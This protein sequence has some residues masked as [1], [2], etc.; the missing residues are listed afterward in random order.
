MSA[1]SPEWSTSPA[2]RIG[3]WAGPVLA[4]LVVTLAATFLVPTVLGML[5]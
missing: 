5:G 3:L 2:R 4:A 1:A